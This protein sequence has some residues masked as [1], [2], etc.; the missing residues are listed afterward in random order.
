MDYTIIK[1]EP[2]NYTSED[3]IQL[4]LK[5]LHNKLY[6]KTNPSICIPYIDNSITRQLVYSIFV[7]LNIG[8]IDTITINEN[9]DKKS[10][11]VIIKFKNWFNNT[12]ANKLKSS[13]LN[14]DGFN[15]VYDFPNYWKCF[16]YETGIKTRKYK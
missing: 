5:R 11:K 4:E 16:K 8:Y 3:E 12:R 14:D 6:K 10:S 13:L 15:L 7:K 9:F 1:G 2:E